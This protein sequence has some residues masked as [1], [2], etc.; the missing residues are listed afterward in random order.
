[1]RGFRN[2]RSLRRLVEDELDPFATP[3][4]GRLTVEGGPYALS[5][6]L[7][8]SV[9]MALHDLTTNA[10]K[11]GA[12]GTA[13]TLKLATAAPPPAMSGQTPGQAKVVA[14]SV[15]DRGDGI[16]PEHLPRLTERFYRVDSA[17]SREAGGTGLGLAIVK[18]I[19]GRHR[20]YL[21]IEST[22][23]V[24]STFTAYLPAKS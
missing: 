23:G 3:G 16:P 22:V 19:V 8:Q 21:D 10:V 12:A 7:A 17:R 18:H 1:M 9:A 14:L 15:T 20:G 4:D 5:P 6:Q 13:V 2:T 24:G 11:Y